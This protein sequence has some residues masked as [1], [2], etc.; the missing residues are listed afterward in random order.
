MS[1]RE[2]PV[3]SLA[4]IDALGRAVFDRLPEPFRM[5]CRDVV[6]RVEDLPDAEVC[7]AMALDSPME[8]LGL[9]HGVDLMRG[10][11]LDVRQDVDRIYLYRLP[12]LAAWQTE[13]DSLEALV[14]NVLI[15]EIGHHFGFSDDDMARI[16]AE[17]F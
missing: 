1:E 6:I 8:L 7:A 12:I 16:E 15:H 4:D 14:G 10:S 2:A 13:R 3:P 5:M 11:V 9:Y 17:D